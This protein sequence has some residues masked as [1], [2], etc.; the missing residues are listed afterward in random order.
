MCIKCGQFDCEGC[1]ESREEQ[2]RSK[3]MKT[4]VYAFGCLY[5]S[6]RLSLALRHIDL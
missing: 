5:Y 1:Y 6:V 2:H 4:D 3:T